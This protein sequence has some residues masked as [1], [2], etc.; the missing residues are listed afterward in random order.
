MVWNS[1][2]PRSSRKVVITGLGVLSPIGLSVAEVVDSLTSA[3]SGVVMIEA[4][5]LRKGFPAATVKQTFDDQFTKLEL[6]YLDRCQ[7]LAVIAAR[8]AIHDAGLN[9]FTAYGLRAGVYYG[10]V[11]GGKTTEQT[12]Y[13]Q[14]FTEGKQASRPFWPMAGMHHAGAAHISIRHQVLGPVVTHASACS[15]SGVAIGDAVRAIR[16][17]YL[18][19]ALAGGAEA[20]LAACTIGGFEGMRALAAP[21]PNDVARSCKPFS[22]NRCGFVLGEGA[23]FF[24]L[25]PEEKALARGAKVYAHLSGYGIAADGH[26]I[27][28]PHPNGQAAAMRAALDDA[29]LAP[30]DID[31]INAHATAT[32][33]GDV[34]E[35]NAIRSVFGEGPDTVLVSSTKS[36]HGHLL[37]AASALELLVTVVGMTESIVPATAHLEQLDPKCALNHVANRPRIGMPVERAMSFSSGFGGTNVALIV[38]KHR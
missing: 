6:A 21:D 38:S 2:K 7:Q 3:R 27:G 23:A 35:A 25:E 14:M 5:P 37:G 19:V 30:A 18:D 24:V 20:P 34:V 22:V 28:T 1:E 11:A 26:H 13:Q 31:Y 4:P 16:D 36:V 15:A 9:D 33:G 8:N 17:G 12:W 29:G 10:N 32:V